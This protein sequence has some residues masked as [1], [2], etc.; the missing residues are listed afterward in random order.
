MLSPHLSL[1]SLAQ[2]LFASDS[3]LKRISFHAQ[4]FVLVNLVIPVAGGSICWPVRARRK[5]CSSNEACD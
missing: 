3:D 5:A 2:S 1:D 4:L